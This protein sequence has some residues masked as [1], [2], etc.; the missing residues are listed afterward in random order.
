VARD[1]LLLAVWAT[2]GRRRSAVT[3]LADGRLRVQVAAPAVDGRANRELLRFLAGELRVA[4]S[5]LA[6]VAGQSG[7]RKTIAIAA[8]DPA[9]VATRLGLAGGDA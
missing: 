8:L 6:V 3:G 5:D 7:R 1:G 2:P 4:P 9:T